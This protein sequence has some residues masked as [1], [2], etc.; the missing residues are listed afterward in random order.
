MKKPL[1]A[2][3][4]LEFTLP[5][6]NSTTAGCSKRPLFLD[7]VLNSKK[8]SSYVKVTEVL[9]QLLLDVV[10]HVL[11][12]PSQQQQLVQLV[13]ASTASSHGQRTRIIHP[14]GFR[15]DGVSRGVRQ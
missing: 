4:F 12:P 2:C 8:R 11:L 14:D 7:S 10:T 13:E 5:R 6:V 15:A 9:V 1:T 3:L